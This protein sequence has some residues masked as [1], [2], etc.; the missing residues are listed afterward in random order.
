MT[1]CPYCPHHCDIAHGGTG[2][3]GMYTAVYDDII[4]RFP[5]YWLM[6][7]PVSV[8]TIP[9]VHAYPQAKALQISTIGCNLKCPGCVSEVLVR[10]PDDMGTGLRYQS[11]KAIIDEA[12]KNDCR[13]VIFCLNEPT[14]SLPSFLRVAHLAK[15]KGMFVGCS[16]NGY[17]SEHSLNL[18][19]SVVDM[20]NIGLKGRD[21]KNL[22]ACGIINDQ[23]VIQNIKKLVQ[24]GVHV[25]IALMHAK[26][27]ENEVI[28]QAKEIVSISGRIPIQ[29]MRCMAFGDLGQEYE[30]SIPESELLCDKIREFA[31]HVYLLNSP[32]TAYIN[33]VCPDCG[34]V[35]SIRE[36]YGPMGCRPVTYLDTGLCSCGYQV[37]LSGIASPS[38][39][40]EEGMDG[41]YRPTR[42]LE[43]IQ[44]I[45][46]C[47]GVDDPLFAPRL[48]RLYLAHGKISSIHERIQKISSYYDIISEVAE[49]VNKKDAGEELQSVL[50]EMKKKVT[51]AVKE[52]THPR[53]LYTMGYPIFS[54][55]GGRFENQLVDVAG[56]NPVNR[57]IKRTG[58][59]GINLSHEEF[60]SL[61]PDWICISGLF[62][63]PKEECIAYCENHDLIVPAITE[64]NVIELPPSWDFGSPRW[65][66]GLMLLAQSFH[67]EK[68]TWNLDEVADQFYQRF[69]HVPYKS[70]QPTR[71]FIKASAK[72][73][74]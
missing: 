26:G 10:K 71:S 30:P 25:E 41:G 39:Y 64:K 44:G 73:S 3:C 11:A 8:E 2:I 46:T 37:P 17:F 5:D 70:V 12:E 72:I 1:N 6:V 34:D 69:Y 9:F 55:N 15:E 42:A 19:L 56:G 21:V 22:R 14:V 58:K 59:P 16:S 65:I 50:E 52:T 4:E 51:D 63:L 32:G 53:V 48:W 36:M 54:L 45:V 66:L 57:M 40:E 43:C 31:D 18:L 35:L 67:P 74:G 7:T 38:R 27:Q 13:G 47:L 60:L 68:C 24:A 20:I 29:I 62:S 23:V 49:T 28:S 61:N 33:T